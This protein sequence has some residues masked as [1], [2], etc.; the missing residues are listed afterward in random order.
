MPKCRLIALHRSVVTAEG[1]SHPSAAAG[2]SYSSCVG[3]HLFTAAPQRLIV[4]LRLLP[5]LTTVTG[6]WAAA[7]SQS[8]QD[9]RDNTLW[10]GKYE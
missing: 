1:Q 9:I 10:V 2:Q 3:R 4:A 6:I 5:R 8:R 7:Q